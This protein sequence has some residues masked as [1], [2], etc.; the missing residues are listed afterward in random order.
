[1]RT[2]YCGQLNLS[3]VGQEVTLCGWVNRRR[4]LGGLIFID[5]RDREGIVQV[6]FDPDEKVAFDKAYDLRNEFCIQIV[7]TVRARPDSQI[8]KDMATGEVE[9]FAH[10]LE[11]INRSEPLPLDSN[12]VNSEEARLKYRYLDLRRPEMA[13]RLKTRAK[14]TSFVRRFMDSHGFLDIETPMLTKATPEGA[15]DY[16][17]PSRVHK[18]KFY[19]LPQSP[20]LFK[21]LLMM[22]G[23]DRYY[24][25]VKCFRD[26]DLR[27]DR[28]PEFTQIDVETSFMTADQVR[29]VMEKLARELWLDVKGVDLGDFP[30]MTFAEAM[31]RFGSDKP[32][33]RNP[34]ELVDVADL[35]KDVEFKV[36]SGPANDAKGR[37][38]AIRVPGGAQLTRKQI[39]EYGAFVN[40]YGA[41]GLAWLKVNDRAAGMEG[42]QSPIA[43]FLSADVLEAVLARTDAQTGDI[44]FFGADSFKIVTD[45]MGA[46]RLKLG[47]DLAL[48]QLDSWAPLWVVDFP[49]FEE[50]EEGGL[51]AMHHP[52]TSPR[53]MSPEELAAAPV[54][55]IANAY[56]MV[57][58]GYEVGGGS[59]RIHRSEMQQTVFSILGINEHEQREK[60]GFLL[61]AL[62]YGT[63]PHAGLAFGLDRLVMLLTGTDNIRDVIAFPKTTAA[64]CLMTDAPSFANPASLQELAISVVKKAGA[65]QE[66]E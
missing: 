60:F 44:L 11:I 36:F 32:D 21:Q 8:N 14:I 40:I 24:Q 66:S 54:N 28:Q 61:D 59:V 55:A 29:E 33:L 31:R 41:K 22:S 56:D 4:D 49:M 50:D 9:V 12:Q 10:A 17:V 47:R 13:E 39:D 1:M 45:A 16:L 18:G 65:E 27:A 57:I 38:A 42:V 3:H 46:L 52:F 2:E 25:I 48:T 5:M 7:G 34:L 6:F 62:K 53:D 23:F 19:A 35:V 43:K 26:E 63:P 64:A 20:Q 30:V 58:N 15:R 51:A 37:V